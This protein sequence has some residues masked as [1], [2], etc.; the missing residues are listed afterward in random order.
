MLTVSSKGIKQ[1][2]YVFFAFPVILVFT[3]T[4]GSTNGLAI[5]TLKVLGLVSA[6]TLLVTLEHPEFNTIIAVN[7]ASKNTILF[8][9]SSSLNC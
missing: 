9:F 7:T 8:I 6:V 1:K 5:L 3:S 4:A 2:R